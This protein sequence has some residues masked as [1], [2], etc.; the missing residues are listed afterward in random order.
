MNGASRR[1]FLK[2][3][4][5]LAGLPLITPL[6]RAAE[7][8]PPKGP[9]VVVVGGGFA[10]AVAAKTLRMASR[11]L[12]VVL[13]E[14]NRSYTALP[15]ANW[16]IGG[17]RR[18]GENRLNY[19]R[20]ESNYGITM[21]YGEALAVDVA[22]KN[23]V[24]AAGTLAYD[25]VVVAPGI[26]FRSEAI[27]GYVPAETPELFPHA[28]TS[29]EEIVALKRRLEDMKDGGLV[30]VSLPLPPYR[31]PQA[32]YERISQIAWYLKQ[33]KPRSKIVVL[34]ANPGI[35]V[36]AE[37]FGRGWERDYKGLIEYRGGQAVTKIDAARSR[38]VTAAETLRADVVNLIPPQ[39]AGAL[40]QRSGLVGADQRWCAVD[41]TTYE[42]AVA[43]GVHIIGD[44]CLTAGMQKSAST[45]NA[46]GKACALAIAGLLGGR[47]PR[48][49][50]YSDVGYS[51]L[52]DREG[53]S[54]IAFYRGEGRQ[55]VPLEKGGGASPDW[56]ELEGV[57]ARAW[58]GS[59]IAEMST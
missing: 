52:N 1:R 51:L 34:D 38:L 4:G 42:S 58:L 43:S 7:L 12:D 5:A 8:L 44:A 9:R 46:Q 22:A 37:L 48:P 15:G 54:A 36:L 6:L 45:A 27:E 32:A 40:A 24:L 50:I 21:V 29:G 35:A 13:V 14:R 2:A 39:V 28:W 41:H 57:Y 31:C 33:A 11:D 10:G 59:M 30:A 53:A 16:V 20:L 56:S 3:A 49:N 47:K 25:H 26:G 18:I 23:V 17:S 19:D 55:T